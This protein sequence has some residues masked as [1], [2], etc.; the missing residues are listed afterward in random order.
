MI[1]RGGGGG[2]GA[3]D[4][5]CFAVKLQMTRKFLRFSNERALK[6]MKIAVNR[7]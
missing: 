6:I 4:F 3:V 1:I 5:V 2:G 7:F